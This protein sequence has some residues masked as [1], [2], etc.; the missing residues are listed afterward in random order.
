MFP[1]T[2]A[3]AGTTGY[4]GP[5][6]AVR[7]R[8]LESDDL[9]VVASLLA[10]PALI[11]RRGMD[12]DRPVARSV[13]ALTAALESEVEPENGET[14][15]IDRDVIVGLARVDW[16]WDALTPWAH[17]VIAPEHQRR[18]NGTAAAWLIFDHVFRETVAVVVQSGVP[19]WDE[20]G[21]AFAR[22]LGTVEAGRRRRVGIRDGAYFDEVEFAMLRTDWEVRRAARG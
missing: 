1:K 12:N 17:V 9:P 6:S 11:G 4:N 10:H 8:P 7:L 19:S 13:A 15:V 2:T 3:P 18:G 14:W 22:S 5:M 20:G 21:A 16:W